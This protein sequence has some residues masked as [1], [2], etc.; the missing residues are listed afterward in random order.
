MGTVYVVCVC[1]CVWGEGG[2]LCVCVC[3][4][5]GWMGGWVGVCVMGGGCGGGSN[6]CT[7]ALKSLHLLTGR[8]E[9]QQNNQQQVSWRSYTASC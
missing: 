2:G 5:G 1:V 7:V 9:N 4:G 6:S 8:K 3:V